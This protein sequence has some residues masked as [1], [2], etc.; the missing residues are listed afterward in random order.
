MSKID[1]IQLVKEKQEE[2]KAEGKL[3]G[4]E[5]LREAIKQARVEFNKRN[6]R[7]L[8]EKLTS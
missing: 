7:R 4:D 1:W 6:R 3:K 2:L 5:L 8:R